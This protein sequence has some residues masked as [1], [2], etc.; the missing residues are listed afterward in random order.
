MLPMLLPL[1]ILLSVALLLP[2]T[3]TAQALPMPLFPMPAD[4]PAIRVDGALDEA[5]WAATTPHTRF[6]RFRPD[7]QNDVGPYRT[8]VRVIME[9]GALVFGIRAWDPQ[10]ADIR[11][12]LARRDQIFPDQDAVTVWL[13]ASGRSEVA[14]FVRV[15]AAGSIADGI[16]RASDGEEDSTPD[17]LDVE[18]ATRRLPDGYSVEMRWPLSVMRYPLNGKLP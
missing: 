2:T 3:G 13:D 15:N 10:P 4:A 11:A 8:E 18:V 17:Y 5:V 7:S 6:Q 16:Y 14:Q 1:G 12:P 9:R